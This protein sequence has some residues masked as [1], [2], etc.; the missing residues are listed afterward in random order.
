MRDYRSFGI[1]LVGALSLWPCSVLAVECDPSAILREDVSQYSQHISVFLALQ[2]LY[3]ND[4]NA[5]H[6][7]NAGFVYDGFPISAADAGTFAQA[8]KDSTNYSLNDDET[9]SILKS[10]LSQASVD[11]YIACVTHQNPPPIAISMNPEVLTEPKFQFKVHWHPDYRTPKEAKIVLMVTN[12]TIEGK[13]KYSTKMKPSDEL[14]FEVTRDDNGSKRLMISA[15]IWG[16]TSDII[17][18]PP[19]PTFE[20]KLQSKLSDVVGLCRS[21]GCG[22]SS[23][24]FGVTIVPDGD[25][26]LLPGTLRFIVQQMRGNPD[27][28][29]TCPETNASFPHHC[30]DYRSQDNDPFHA[31]GEVRGRAGANESDNFISGRFMV[32]Q[33]VIDPITVHKPSTSFR[34]VPDKSGDLNSIITRASPYP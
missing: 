12:G 30:D 15:S 11:A 14:P 2:H 29:Y 33:T 31:T 16:K 13:T 9:I 34:Q 28:I 25:S 18:V 6:N 7:A 19:L 3:T 27:E 17:S 4:V 22:T 24:K 20:A 10:T 23:V 26:R 8:I 5:G 21:G 1:S 32:L